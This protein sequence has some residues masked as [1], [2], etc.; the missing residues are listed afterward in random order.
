MQLKSLN[1]NH[2]NKVSTEMT[3]DSLH[4]LINDLIFITTVNQP[5]LA[6]DLY[7]QLQRLN[8][9]RTYSLYYL[10]AGLLIN[11]NDVLEEYFDINNLPLLVLEIYL[12]HPQYHNKMNL[13]RAWMLFPDQ[14]QNRLH[15]VFSVQEKEKITR[16]QGV[17]SCIKKYS[18]INGFYLLRKIEELDTQ[19]CLN[20]FDKLFFSLLKNNIFAAETD[21]ILYG[22]SLHKSFSTM[23]KGYFLLKNPT[24]KDEIL[25]KLVTKLDIHLWKKVPRKKAAQF[26]IDIILH[27]DA[28]YITKLL[29]MIG[30]DWLKILVMYSKTH[31]VDLNNIEMDRLNLLLATFDRTRSPKIDSNY[32]V[33]FFYLIPSRF[34]YDVAIRMPELAIDRNLVFRD[35]FYYFDIYDLNHLFLRLKRSGKLTSFVTAALIQ[36]VRRTYPHKIAQLDIWF[37]GS[38]INYMTHLEETCPKI[39]GLP[40][41]NLI[42]HYFCLYDFHQLNPYNYRLFNHEKLFNKIKER[43]I[44]ADSFDDWF[45]LMFALDKKHTDKEENLSFLY[46]IGNLIRDALIKNDLWVEE[47]TKFHRAMSGSNQIA[48]KKIQIMTYGVG[49]FEQA[50]DIF[51]RVLAT[52]VGYSYDDLI[53]KC[54]GEQPTSFCSLV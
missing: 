19:N 33:A 32:F 14:L 43:I 47:Y 17:I 12:E 46:S 13:I 30:S 22:V 2:N 37:D 10:A 41:K 29:K 21:K 24:Y 50:H 7:N 6:I 3:V 16:W 42:L 53:Q 39:D 44:K 51:E 52:K 23:L 18:M 31:F 27:K 5:T 8:L 20:S 48:R 45:T 49:R 36:E 4:E 38:I 11:S 26:I 28:T 15:Q 40:N 35:I 9:L 25:W 34:K 1:D 54:N